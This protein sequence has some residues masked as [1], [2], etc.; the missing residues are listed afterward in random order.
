MNLYG[1]SGYALC[2]SAQRYWRDFSIG[3]RHGIFTIDVGYEI[4][5][6]HLLGIEPNTSLPTFL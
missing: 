5:G 1:A 2:S 3:A 6:R 4:A